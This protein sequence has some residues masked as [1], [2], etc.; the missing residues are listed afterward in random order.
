MG[1]FVGCA[2]V[3]LRG[4]GNSGETVALN[5]MRVY[6]AGYFLSNAISDAIMISRCYPMWYRQVLVVAVPILL[7]LACAGLGYAYLTTY[8]DADA[9]FLINPGQGHLLGPLMIPFVVMHILSSL[10]TTLLLAFKVFLVMKQAK[11]ILGSSVKRMYSSM[12]AI[13]CSANLNCFIVS[14]S[15][16]FLPSCS[17]SHTYPQALQQKTNDITRRIADSSPGRHEYQSEG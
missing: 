9:A 7:S 10:S 13:M 3:G 17:P 8:R 12:L 2:M 4:T 6:V 5:L 16:V 1:F 15:F 14:L 11:V